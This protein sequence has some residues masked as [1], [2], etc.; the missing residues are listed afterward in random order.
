MRPAVSSDT[1]AHPASS[2]TPTTAITNILVTFI[3]LLL[4]RY[5]SG[6]SKMA[7]V[8]VG[9]SPQPRA[10]ASAS[11]P[12]RKTGAGRRRP[13]PP[14]PPPPRGIGGRGA[15]QRYVRFLKGGQWS[16]PPHRFIARRQERRRSDAENPSAIRSAATRR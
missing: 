9:I 15:P 13:P 6:P 12:S 11:S 10:H 1:V 3:A 7:R 2:R 8:A 5:L 14:A 16:P 4:R